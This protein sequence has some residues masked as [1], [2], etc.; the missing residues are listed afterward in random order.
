MNILSLVCPLFPF[1]PPLSLF[2]FF[3][4]ADLDA[5][6]AVLRIR[7]AIVD[8]TDDPSSEVAASFV[9]R[10]HQNRFENDIQAVFGF[11]DEVVD[12]RVHACLFLLPPYGGRYRDLVMRVDVQVSLLSRSQATSNVQTIAR[13]ARYCNVI[14]V[15]ARSDGLAP[16][17]LA[18]LK[19]TVRTKKPKQQ[20]RKRGAHH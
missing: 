9:K 12:S 1:E 15:I 3:F 7:A 2:T 10:Q 13:L 18:S 14:P 11:A 17:E 20:G 19:A 8:V 16:D 5:G 6:H 4:F